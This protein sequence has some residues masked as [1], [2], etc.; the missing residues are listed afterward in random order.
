MSRPVRQCSLRRSCPLRL[1]LLSGL[2]D[3]DLYCQGFAAAAK[4]GAAH[5]RSAKIIEPGGDAHVR[6]GDA[7]SVRRVEADPAKIFNMSFR[8]CMASVLGRYTVRAAKVTADITRRN[9]KRSRCCHED[10]SDI[11][12]NSAL[13]RKGFR[14]GGGGMGRV[15]VEGNPA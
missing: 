9:S 8:P 13:E 1:R 10:V 14:R 7:N 3:A 2:V 5:R 4:P 6:I 12:T 11:L 15:C